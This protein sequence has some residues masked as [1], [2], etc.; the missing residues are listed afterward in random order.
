MPLKNRPMTNN[1]TDAFTGSITEAQR[2]VQIC[3]A[4]RYCEGYCAVFPAINRQ[5]SFIQTD[6]I[7]L[8]NLCHNCQGCYHAC[9]YTD[10][11]EFSINLPKALADVRVKSWQH[12]SYPQWFAT[13]FQQHG[14]A[15][16]VTLLLAVI[17]FLIL[18]PRLQPA[19]GEGFYATLSHTAM[20]L[21]FAPAFIAPLI[22]IGAGI[23]HYWRD[24]GGASLTLAHVGAAL[25]SA[26][27]LKNLSGGQGQGCNFEDGDRFNNNRR[28]LHQA[29]MYGFLL[30]FASTSS[31][32]MM[33]YVFNLQAPYSLLSIPKLL[34]IP[35]G[36]LLT[37]GCVGLAWLKLR[38]DES[39]GA[40]AVWGGE[41]AF[42]LLLGATGATGLALYLATGTPLVPTLLAIH[43]G[44]VLT[45]FV[46]M[47][48]SKMMHG[49][50]RMAALLRDAQKQH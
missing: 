47:P 22:I 27:T 24:S 43:L 16:A 38:A 39:L 50:F 37:V 33:H 23:R 28:W 8:A 29:A 2:Q 49:F 3:N 15:V 31:A 32:T 1:M 10:P 4:C 11:H 17:L 26:A 5:R 45:L 6:I 35:G 42:T 44:T 13:R 36:V 25:R 34:G 12:Y 19:S 40:S 9:Q 20:V 21:L 7:Q 30:C 48:Y 14:V 18:I 46:L 41:M